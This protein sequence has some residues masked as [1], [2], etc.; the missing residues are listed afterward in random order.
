M[1]N[2]APAGEI[3]LQ[4]AEGAKKDANA[5]PGYQLKTEPG[6]ALHEDESEQEAFHRIQNLIWNI[7]QPHKAPYDAKLKQIKDAYEGVVTA[8][9]NDNTMKKVFPWVFIVTD[10]KLSTVLDRRPRAVFE[11][12]LE[13]QKM[14]LI[15]AAYETFTTDVDNGIDLDSVDYTWHWY[16]EL[17]GWAVK[18]IWFET[19]TTVCYDPQPER[20]D[21]GDIVYDTDGFPKIKYDRKLY[22][23]GLVK[24]RVCEP[25]EVIV[26]PNARTLAEA[27]WIA[28]VRKMHFDEWEQQYKFNPLYKN[29]ECVKPGALASYSPMGTVEGTDKDGRPAVVYASGCALE[30]D[31]VLI[32]EFYY[33]DRDEYHVSFNNIPSLHTPNPCP[34]DPETGKKKLPA[35]DL[36]AHPRPDTFYSRGPGELSEVWITIYQRLMN[37]RARRAEL[38][39]APVVLTD[40]SSGI[41]PK[42]FKVY[43]GAHWRG[44]KGRA[45]ILNLA[46]TDTGEVRE[47]L[48][49]VKDGIKLTIGIDIERFIADPDPTAFQQAARDAAGQIRPKKDLARYEA[50][51]VRSMDITIQNIQFWMTIP[52]IVDMAEASDEELAEIKEWDKLPQTEDDKAAG[53]QYYRKYAKIRTKGMR[54]VEEYNDDRFT[55]RPN[56]KAGK[57]ADGYVNSRPEFIRTKGKVRCRAISQRKQAANKQLQ[58]EISSNVLDRAFG[59]PPKN[60]MEI[61]AAMASGKPVKPQYYI[62]RDEAVERY[63]DSTGEDVKEMTAPEGEDMDSRPATKAVSALMKTKQTMLPSPEDDAALEGLSVRRAG[64]KCPP[65]PNE[66]AA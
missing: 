5:S 10:A 6:T 17:Y 44:M 57:D 32:A 4:F 58:F 23:K 49:E 43:P 60:E 66:Q 33:L 30:Q 34:P 9:E 24:Q 3:K 56:K 65:A 41:N 45:E 25:D 63:I 50:A 13:R 37:S 59:L 20:D 53:R 35:A 40:L 1:T 47:Y 61:Q 22:R 15:E 21:N 38:A 14:P 42:S 36:H 2:A 8:A 39:A 19:D 51:H 16:N 48:E 55:L 64:S 29:T 62:N 7:G 52:E 18:R 26:D 46:G 12:D 31:Q 27:R 11:H 28:F 54:Y